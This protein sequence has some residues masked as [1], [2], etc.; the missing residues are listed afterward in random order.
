MKTRIYEANY[1]PT[2]QDGR[3]MSI[4]FCADS[5]ELACDHAAHMLH[6]QILKGWR[7]FRVALC[8][9]ASTDELG[10][11]HVTEEQFT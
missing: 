4:R 9:G 1:V 6:E 8:P 10:L 7:L 3:V 11:F 5:K 2:M